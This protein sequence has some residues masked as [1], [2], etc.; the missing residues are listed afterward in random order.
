MFKRNK[1]FTTLEAVSAFSIWTMITVSFIPMFHQIALHRDMIEKE[2]EAYR[3][4]DEKISRYMLTGRFQPRETEVYQ[5]TRFNI[6][7]KEKGDDYKVCISIEPGKKE[8]HCFTI[9]Q[10]KGLYPS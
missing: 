2:E 10:T 9:L 6:D 8:K 5:G 3:I 4:L 7:W 1:G